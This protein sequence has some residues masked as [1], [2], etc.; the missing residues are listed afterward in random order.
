MVLLVLC[1]LLVV[2]IIITRRIDTAIEWKVEAQN[3][4][5]K[6]ALDYEIACND[7]ALRFIAI[8]TASWQRIEYILPSFSSY[9]LEK[10]NGTWYM[11][12]IPTDA[13]ATTKY[14]GKIAGA[15]WRCAVNHAKPEAL[16]MADYVL[17]ITAANGETLSYQT[18]VVDTSYIIQDHNGQLYSGNSDSL[19]WQLYFGKHRFIPSLSQQ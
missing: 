4:N 2:G 3:Q 13:L 9:A 8:D 1:G 18:F 12:T 14:M 6:V 19:F 5:R 7:T 10:Q 15:K 16:K 11:D 17:T